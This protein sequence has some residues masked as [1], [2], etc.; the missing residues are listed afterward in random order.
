MITV[1]DVKGT[2]VR[3][4]H[5]RIYPAAVGALILMGHLFAV[6][7]YTNILICLLASVGFLTSDSLRHFILPFCAY[8][9]QVSVKH[10]P[11][12]PSYSGLNF[13][14]VRGVTVAILFVVL[15]T[16]LVLFFVRN[17]TRFRRVGRPP[18]LLSSGVLAL[19]F[20][21]N[22]ALGGEWIPESLGFGAVVALSFLA[23]GYLF[24]IGLAKESVEE[25][26]SYFIFVTAV[27]AW[28]LILETA[29]LYIS[30]KVIGPDGA[31][32]KEN[33]LY[34]WGIWTTAGMGL[35]VLLPV[36]F[37]GMIR[38]RQ[39][40]FYAVTAALSAFAVLLNLSR[41]ALLVAVLV[42][43]ISFAVGCFFGERRRIFRISGGAIVLGALILLCIFFEQ[44][45]TLLM[46]YLN[47]G[48]SDN[49]R[50]AL[51]EY[52]A[53]VFREAPL[54][55]KG[56]FGLHTDTF[57]AIDFLPQMLHNTPIQLA[58]SMGAFGLFSYGYYRLRTLELF[59]LRPTL[60][61]TM[62]GLSMLALLLG[63][64]F[65]NFIFYIQ[66]TFYYSVALAIVLLSEQSG[67]KRRGI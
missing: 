48:F 64:L 67:D 20:I 55:G 10:A 47:R 31:A 54:F 34:G 49:G 43:V 4:F 36:L 60:E 11:G 19:A 7:F 23:V 58:A 57:Q 24:Y 1:T 66:P 53:R 6:E 14:G 63:S 3:I 33:I 15:G 22:G 37:L 44:T 28:V 12:M 9:Y 17:R 40:V 41:A 25:L 13:S 38:E 45:V 32:I 35:A 51:W 39:A 59:L 29:E 27:I 46:D 30:G 18:L 5:G 26:L 2:L 21:M 62:L 8:I 61:K 16:C 50:F 52:G 65:D 56:F 42:G